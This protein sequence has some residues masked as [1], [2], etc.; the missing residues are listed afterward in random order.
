MTIKAQTDSD[1][2]DSVETYMPPPPY[3]GPALPVG[4]APPPAPDTV[5]RITN[6][7][8]YPGREPTEKERIA[9]WS[10][11]AAFCGFVLG[12]KLRG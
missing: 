2:S 4:E 8:P 7:G 10:S 5:G 3:T 6:L 11:L 9:F 12:L 1:P